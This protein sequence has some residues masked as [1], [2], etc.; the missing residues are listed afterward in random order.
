MCLSACQLLKKLISAL[1]AYVWQQPKS[2]RSLLLP[3]V[4]D[5]ATKAKAAGSGLSQI[6]SF[7]FFF[8]KTGLTL[9][10]EATEK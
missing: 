5:G 10:Q 7:F 8:N 1:R 9:A 4:P 6:M 2:L 3:S